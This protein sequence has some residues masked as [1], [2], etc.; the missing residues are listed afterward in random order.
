MHLRH[1]TLHCF[2]KGNSAKDTADE[3]FTVCGSGTTT[4]RTVGNWFKK[5][6]AGN[7]ELKDEDRSGRPATTDTDIIKTVLAENP[8]Y[9]V[10]EIVDA[11]NI[12]KTTVH[13]HL[14]KIGYANRYEVWVP[15]LLTETG[16][17]NR[18][19][20]CDLLVEAQP[21]AEKRPELANRRGDNARPHVALV[22]R[23]KLLQF[24][25]P[26]EPRLY[27]R[28]ASLQPELANRR[29]VV[30]HHDN[31]RPHV[32]LAVRQKLLQFDWDVLSY[33]LQT[34]LHP[35]T[36]LKNFLRGKS[37]KSISEIKTHLDE[38]GGPRAMGFTRLIPEA[39]SDVNQL[40]Y[41]SLITDLQAAVP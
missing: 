8:R 11:T 31:A 29:G 2:R 1:V 9:S 38:Y 4:I 3:I 39:L 10:R 14:I 25:R 13:E 37:F 28:F 18:V 7:F 23:Q 34:L 24:D 35:I 41:G 19:S 22:V 5:F 16:L 6:R 27:V 26:Y 21:V 36:T 40:R 20:T 32:A 17:M 30:F 15:H 33:P 12:P